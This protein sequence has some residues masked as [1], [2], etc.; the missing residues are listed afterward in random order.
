MDTQLFDT[1]SATFVAWQSAVWK[2]NDLRNNL[3]GSLEAED[4]FYAQLI[5]CEKKRIALDYK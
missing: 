3:D 4:A 1:R 2:A 5:E